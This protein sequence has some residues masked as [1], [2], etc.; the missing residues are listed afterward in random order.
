MGAP[1]VLRPLET[2]PVIAASSLLIQHCRCCHCSTW[3]RKHGFQNVAFFRNIR[4]W[5]KSKSII[6]PRAIHRRQNTL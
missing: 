3:R 6:L 4:W 5:T 2:G 1:T